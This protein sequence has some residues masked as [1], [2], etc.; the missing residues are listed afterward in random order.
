MTYSRQD[1]LD[2][3]IQHKELFRRDSKATR[4][5][6]FGSY[7]RGDNGPTRDIDIVVELKKPDMFALIGI[8][9]SIELAPVVKVDIVSMRNDVN[10]LLKR[11]I[12]RD[13]VYV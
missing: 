12:E 1:I 11:R 2:F 9:Q 7:T 6:L 8:M 13:A 3:L 10:P 5:G 4:L